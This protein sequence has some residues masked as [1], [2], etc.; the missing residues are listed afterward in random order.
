MAWEQGKARS[1]IWPSLKEEIRYRREGGAEGDEHV[2]G[3]IM[4]G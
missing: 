1:G 3:M 4:E 2:Q